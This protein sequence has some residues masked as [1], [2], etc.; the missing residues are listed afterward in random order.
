MYSLHKF[1][2]ATFSLFNY[3]FNSQPITFYIIVIV[4]NYKLFIV[5]IMGLYFFYI[6]LIYLSQILLPYYRYTVK[7]QLFCANY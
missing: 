2:F 6:F 5:M 4:I 1:H 3:R 7:P